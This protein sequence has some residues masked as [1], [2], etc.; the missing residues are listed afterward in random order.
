VLFGGESAEHEV[1]L[2]SARNVIEAIDRDLYD[3]VLIGID[4][5]GRWHASDESRFVADASDPRRIHLPPQGGDLAI[6]PGQDADLMVVGTGEM[7]PQVDVVFPVLHGP[8][9]EDGTVQGLLRLAHLPFVGPDVLGSAIAMDKEV[10][11]RLLRDAG[12]PVTPFITVRRHEISPSW[13][14]IRVELG[15][16]VFVKPANMGSS[17]GVSSAG[18]ERAYRSALELAFGFDTKVLIEQAAPGREIEC[19]VLGNERPEASVPGEIVPRQ[20]FYSYEAKYLDDD[21]ADLRVPADLNPDTVR[22]VQ[23]LSVRVFQALCCEGMAR[24][25]FFLTTSRTGAF[26]EGELVV[27]EIN[28]IPGFTRISMYPKLWAATGLSYPALVDRLI[29]LGLERAKRDGDL[30][31]VV[32]LEAADPVGVEED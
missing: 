24:V 27:N 6:R 25:D 28:T 29:R 10:A 7:L 18:D 9:G 32:D 14:E 17:V 5:S 1:S 23:E 22:R 20:G 11:K 31:S 8:L 30:A 21:G 12:I 16:P 3:V 2:Q 15:A 13:E 4:R 26:E 19:A